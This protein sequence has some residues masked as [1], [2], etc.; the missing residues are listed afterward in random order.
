MRLKRK[1]GKKVQFLVR[2]YGGT[3]DDTILNMTEDERNK[4]GMAEVLCIEGNIL[5]FIYIPIDL[6]Y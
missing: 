1:Y 4:Y 5:E 3:E 6:L 2:K